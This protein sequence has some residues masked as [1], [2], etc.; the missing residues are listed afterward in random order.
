[1][2]SEPVMECLGRLVSISNHLHNT[3]VIAIS[4]YLFLS[5]DLGEVA[6]ASRSTGDLSET[7]RA[8]IKNMKKNGTDVGVDQICQTLSDVNKLI[9]RT[10]HVHGQITYR[11]FYKGEF[12]AETKTHKPVVT[13]KSVSFSMP[14]IS[15][16]KFTRSRLE[17]DTI[18]EFSNAVDSAEEA[19]KRLNGFLNITEEDWII[20]YNTGEE[21]S[22]QGNPLNARYDPLPSFL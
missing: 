7:L 20:Y 9:S 6:F 2:K 5:P 10:K 17:Y 4:K 14:S 16:G 18:L 8:I 13:K 15:G 12:D 19:L 3:L 21:R 1:M 11:T 22:E